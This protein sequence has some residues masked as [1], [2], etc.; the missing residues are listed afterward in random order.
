ML[1]R[2]LIS[3]SLSMCSGTH[4]H[5][6]LGAAPFHRGAGFCRAAHYENQAKK[7]ANW[8]MRPDVLPFGA[9]AGR[10]W[11]VGYVDVN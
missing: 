3:S 2:I 11:R 6:A 10:Y 4:D 9:I 1:L 8:Q 5:S 7:Q